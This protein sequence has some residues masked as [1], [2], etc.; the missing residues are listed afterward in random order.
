MMKLEKNLLKSL[1]NRKVI[2][3]ALFDDAQCSYKK[4]IE[5]Y[6]SNENIEVYSIG[7]N[8]VNFPKSD[9]FFYKKNRFI[10]NKS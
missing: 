5:E 9:K 3:W 8:N 2:V 10:I 6:F 1:T 4:A 7:I